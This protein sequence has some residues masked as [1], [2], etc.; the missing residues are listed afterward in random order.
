LGLAVAG[1]ALAL[2]VSLG[3]LCFVRPRAFRSHRIALGMVFVALLGVAAGCV[4][5]GGKTPVGPA[6]VALPNRAAVA[7]VD[8]GEA[9]RLFV[10]P[11]D[12]ARAL[13]QPATTK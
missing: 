6:G 8:K 5:F 12:L 3:G 10:S 4:L 2:A 1:T 13:E 11:D 9:V 7:V